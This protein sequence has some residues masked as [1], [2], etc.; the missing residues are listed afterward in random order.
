MTEELLPQ[1]VASL[2]PFSLRARE[3]PQLVEVDRR[4]GMFVVG[5]GHCATAHAF[6]PLRPSVLCAE[7]VTA[8]VTARIYRG[9][10]T[11]L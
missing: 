9:G 4:R 8:A 11:F 10:L 7:F 1:A 3:F 2:Q 6:V 5:S